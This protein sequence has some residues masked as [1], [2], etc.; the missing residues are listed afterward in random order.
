MNKRTN[1]VDRT[2]A[3]TSMRYGWRVMRP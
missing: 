1:Q 3:D 2:L